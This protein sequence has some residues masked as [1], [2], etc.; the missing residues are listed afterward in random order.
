M[1]DT[2]AITN[3]RNK[4]NKTPYDLS[5]KNPEVGRLLMVRGESVVWCVFILVSLVYHGLVSEAEG[6][7]DDEDSD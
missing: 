2:G 5:V 3:L 1:Y 6:Y 4:D 7:G